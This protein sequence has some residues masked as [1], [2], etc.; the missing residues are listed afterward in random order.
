VLGAGGALDYGC[1]D[2]C[3]GGGGVDNRI[4]GPNPAGSVGGVRHYGRKSSP[5]CRCQP[6][7]ASF[8]SLEAS[9]RC[10]GTSVLPHWVGGVFGRKP[11]FGVELAHW[12]HFD[13][14]PLL[15]ALRLETR[16]AVFPLRSSGVRH[17]PRLIFR[18]TM[19][20]A[21]GESKTTPFSEPTKS[22][23]LLL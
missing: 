12:R 15:G 18:G 1:D 7:W 10:A 8:P 9:L 5:L 19:Y 13:V 22:R 2:K 23:H 16:L 3:Y 6:P 17:C 4:R 21:V 20:D 14:V 11:R